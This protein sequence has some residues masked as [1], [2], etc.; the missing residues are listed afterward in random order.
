MAM[1]EA[2]RAHALAHPR[3]YMLAHSGG[4]ETQ[5]DPAIAEAL[6]LPLQAAFAELVGEARA[7]EALRGMWA[8]LH[9]FASLEIEGQFRRAGD[10][11]RAFAGAIE[12]YLAGWKARI[13]SGGSFA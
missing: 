1:A 9:G 6:A 2:Y 4:E 10:L 13:D 12:A 11:D 3:A 5:I 8:L 7:H